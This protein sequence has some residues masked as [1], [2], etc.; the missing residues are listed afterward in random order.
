M[1]LDVMA[2]YGQTTIYSQNRLEKL[3][4]MY[5]GRRGVPAYVHR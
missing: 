5:S 2:P 3:E 4:G 1:G